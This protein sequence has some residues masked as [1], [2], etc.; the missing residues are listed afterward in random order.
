M[1]VQEIENKANKKIESHLIYENTLKKT[2]AKYNQLAPGTYDILNMLTE[3]VIKALAVKERDAER[4]WAALMK[5]YS[6]TFFSCII[7]RDYSESIMKSKAKEM[8]EELE[9]I[10]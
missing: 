4:I 3:D 6:K 10:K 8:K 9:K 7:E 2:I 1:K 5:Y